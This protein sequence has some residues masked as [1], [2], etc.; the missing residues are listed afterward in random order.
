MTWPM[1][2]EASSSRMEPTTQAAGRMINS[3]GKASKRAL[4]GVATRASISTG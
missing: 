3:V 4:E 1:G 2:E